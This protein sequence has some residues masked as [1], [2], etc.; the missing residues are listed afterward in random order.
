MVT[1]LS[2][3]GLPTN[4]LRKWRWNLITNYSFTGDFLP[5]F[6]VGLGVRWQDKAAIGAPVIAH[7]LFGV[8]PDVRNPFYA[9]SET[10]YDAWIGYR[11]RFEHFDWRIQLNVRNIGVDEELIPVSA[12]PDGSIAGW[13]IAPSQTWTLRSTFSF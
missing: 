3:D 11:R 2:E 6:N 12:Q 4:E 1:R 8:A 9:P 7:P 10:N 13:R 5:G